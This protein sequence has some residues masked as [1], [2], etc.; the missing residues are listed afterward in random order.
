MFVFV[1]VFLRTILFETTFCLDVNQ[2]R[3][4][5]V[6][7]I[8]YFVLLLFPKIQLENDAFVCCLLS[9]LDCFSILLSNNAI[10]AEI[11]Q[12]LISFCSYHII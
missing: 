10:L 2:F 6:R 11:K 12:R 7:F 4:P 5:F 9:L 8:T 3:V 1:F